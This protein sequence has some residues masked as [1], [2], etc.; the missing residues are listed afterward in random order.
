MTKNEDKRQIITHLKLLQSMRQTT[1]SER[2]RELLINFIN[3]SNPLQ[4]VM[5]DDHRLVIIL[6]ISIVKPLIL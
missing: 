3:Y 1:A 2:W 5:E 6:V 4:Q